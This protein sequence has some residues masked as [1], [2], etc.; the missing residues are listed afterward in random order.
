VAVAD[1]SGVAGHGR[2]SMACR[3]GIPRRT[4]C[5][6]DRRRGSHGGLR[7]RRKARSPVGGNPAAVRRGPSADPCAVRHSS[8]E[9]TM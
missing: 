1:E 9:N 2:S 5:R 8:P 3:S 7:R 4:A 6:N